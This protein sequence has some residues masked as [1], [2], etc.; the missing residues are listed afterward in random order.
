MAEQLGLT[1]DTDLSGEEESEGDPEDEPW[2]AG[3]IAEN[4]DTKSGN[5]SNNLTY[6]HPACHAVGGPTKSIGSTSKTVSSAPKSV[7]FAHTDEGNTAVIEVEITGTD[8]TVEDTCL[9]ATTGGTDA[10]AVSNGRRERRGQRQ[11]VDRPLRPEMEPV[12]GP[13]GSDGRDDGTSLDQ[14]GTPPGDLIDDKNRSQDDE[15]EIVVPDDVEISDELHPMLEP[16]GEKPHKRSARHIE[17][18]YEPGSSERAESP[19]D[20]PKDVRDLADHNKAYLADLERRQ[21]EALKALTRVRP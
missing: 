8:N 12:R 19:E 20:L 3:L 18:E 2:D 7:A 11:R 14:T 16:D 21:D 17:P 13:A 6:I 5:N 4:T 15:E 9:A 1:E 10:A